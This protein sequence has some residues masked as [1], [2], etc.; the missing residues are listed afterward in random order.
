MTYEETV[1]KMDEYFINH[2]FGV[3]EFRKFARMNGL[4]YDYGETRHCLVSPDWS[5]VLKIARLDN[6][7]TDYNE[8]ECS[9]YEKAVALGIGK[10]FLPIRKIGSI[11]YKNIGVYAQKKFSIDYS[12]ISDFQAK[13]IKNKTKSLK[14]N[15][16]CQRS[17]SKCYQSYR[18]SE[19][20]YNRAYQIYGKQFMKVFEK[21]TRENQIGDLHTSNLG[22]LKKQPVVIDYAGYFG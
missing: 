21:F 17:K 18:I 15:T 19:H 11:Q 1:K 12:S 20:W 16:I 7:S 3:T 14:S 5:E 6:V 22:F 13:S 4:K 10:I 2:D 9:N 8:I